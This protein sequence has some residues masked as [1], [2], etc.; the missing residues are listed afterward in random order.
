M[1]ISWETSV[2]ADSIV[3]YGLTEDYTSSATGKS[4]WLIGF[5]H[6]VNLN[7]LE[8]DTTYHYRCGSESGWSSDHTFQTPESDEASFIVM[9]DSR[10]DFGEFG[11][12]RWGK[13]ADAAAQEDI[14]FTLFSGDVVL[15]GWFP[16]EWNWFFSE[17]SELML[18]A[19]FMSALGNHEFFSKI[20]FNRFAMPGNEEWY[21]FDCGPVHV[22]VL[23]TDTSF[24]TAV[25]PKLS[26]ADIGP[27]SA[28]YRWLEEDL[29]RVPDDQWKVVVLHRPPYSCSEHGNATDVQ[30]I[31]ELFDRYGVDVVFCG[32][33]HSYQR[34]KP[35]YGGEVS[36]EGPI[37]IV[38]AG[39]GAPLYEVYEAEWVEYT[40]SCYHYTYVE[41]DENTMTI[42][43]KYTDGEIFDSIALT[44]A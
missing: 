1:T 9:G 44:K 11:V 17:G 15:F 18:K 3:E 30:P 23:N 33:D 25:H 28:Q 2:P 29:S 37:Y 32:H 7:E 19:P 27:G 36:E 4:S 24:L 43:A 13:V 21:S 6:E 40:E 22:V 5:T 20:Y 31:T 14:D 35:I 16:W 39:A 41:V 12:E 8:P 38:S 10:N 34:S 42:E 26:P